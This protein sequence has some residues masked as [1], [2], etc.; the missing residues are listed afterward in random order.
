MH[1]VTEVRFHKLIHHVGHFCAG[2]IGGMCDWTVNHDAA[3][4][5]SDGL[6]RG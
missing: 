3:D 5:G 4:S 2:G 6:G 1:H